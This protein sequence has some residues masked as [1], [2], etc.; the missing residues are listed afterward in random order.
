MTSTPRL[1]DSPDRPEAGNGPEKPPLWEPA[2][3]FYRRLH[4]A[5]LGLLIVVLSIHLLREFAVILQQVAIAGFLVYLI[6][7]AQRWLLRRGMPLL[8][9]YIVILLMASGLAFGLG[10]LIYTN[11]QDFLVKAPT[12]RENFEAMTEELQNQLPEWIYDAVL[13]TAIEGSRDAEQNLQRLGAMLGQVLGIVPYLV[14]VA[15]Y[16]VFLLWE[17]AGANE[18]INRAFGAER[19]NTVREVLGNASD[20]IERYISVKTLVSLLIGALTT[21]ALFLF[22]V[23]Y[24]ILWGILTFLLNFIPYLGSFV[25]VV[26]PTLLALVQMRSLGTA[27]AVVVV[28]TVLQNIVALIIEPLL[29]GHRLNLSPLLILVAL[30]FWFSIWGIVGMLLAVPLLVVIKSVLASIEE[31]RWLAQLMS[32]NND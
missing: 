32:K 4:V 26:L 3:R 20:L 9:A 30:A 12:Y 21:I 25:A 23:D 11:F 19:A 31:T 6:L 22:G 13:R 14:L 17:V 2:T 7:P 1:A 24:P 28:L 29:A 16:L 10:T 15:I 8:P 18:R 5:A 27:L